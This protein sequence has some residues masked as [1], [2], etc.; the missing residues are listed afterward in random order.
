MPLD[1]RDKALLIALVAVARRVEREV[2]TVARSSL[3]T[4]F[5]EA[6]RLVL[7]IA[8][9]GI[10]RAYQWRRLQPQLLELFRPANRTIGTELILQLDN[11]RTPVQ[12]AAAKFIR[13]PTPPTTTPAFTATAAR[14]RVLG[15]TVLQEFDDRTGTSPFMQR[16]A[17]AVDRTVQSGLLTNRTTT[18]I[19][20]DVIKVATVRGV[21]RAVAK[22]ASTFRTALHRT[23]NFITAAAWDV[24]NTETVE[25]FTRAPQS[26][27]ASP[28]SAGGTAVAAIRW[29][30]IAVLDPA[31]CPICA[32]LGGQIRATPN[33]FG[34]RPPVH[35]RCR[36][37]LLPRGA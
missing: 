7:S 17:R 21:A 26:S 29:E 22:A 10:F 9:A 25:L 24:V 34:V 20:D 36:C 11:M 14:T 1:E 2:T 18:E 31:T 5:L 12:A 6:R 3:I 13:L 19:A 28:T 16:Q 23:T 37:V 30:W 35:P 8:A 15:T 4:A 33:D 32:P 27:P